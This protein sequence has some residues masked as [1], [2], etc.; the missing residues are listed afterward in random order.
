MTDHR[1]DAGWILDEDGVAIARC[2]VC[3]PNY[4]PPEQREPRKRRKRKRSILRK[5]DP[6]VEPRKPYRDARRECG[7]RSVV[8]I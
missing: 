3:D 7:Q 5:S 4:R 2:Q 1:C 6:R 8:R